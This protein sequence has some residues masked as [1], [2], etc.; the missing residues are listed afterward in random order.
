MGEVKRKPFPDEEI[1]AAKELC[2][3]M[4]E[5]SATYYII[6]LLDEVAWIRQ[7]NSALQAENERLKGELKRIA[8]TVSLLPS[9]TGL[10]PVKRLEDIPLAI[11]DLQECYKDAAGRRNSGRAVN[12]AALEARCLTLESAQQ[13]MA[14]TEER[15]DRAQAEREAVDISRLSREA[16]EKGRRMGLEQAMEICDYWTRCSNAAPSDCIR[17]IRRALAHPAP[18]AKVTEE[19]P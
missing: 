16:L 9:V 2:C 7:V 17:D 5:V 12:V 6:N 11:R 10:S 4:G 8:D 14:A 15:I 19:K 3:R 13:Q 1:Q 18:A